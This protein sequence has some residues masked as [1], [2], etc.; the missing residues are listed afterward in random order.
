MKH[1]H[2]VTQTRDE[3]QT[4]NKATTTT[5]YLLLPLL[6]QQRKWHQIERQKK[7]YKCLRVGLFTT[8]LPMDRD[9]HVSSMVWFSGME[10]VYLFVYVSSGIVIFNT[11]ESRRVM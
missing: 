8:I 10:R 1:T 9:I 4:S 3:R 6:M 11:T 5:Q 2:C 7:M